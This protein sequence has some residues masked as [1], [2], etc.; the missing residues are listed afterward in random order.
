MDN[1]HEVVN[2]DTSFASRKFIM[3]IIGLVTIFAGAILAAKMLGF[4]PSYETMVGGVI[5]LVALYVS[6]N[7]GEKF[8]GGKINS[9]VK[10]AALNVV[11]AKNVLDTQ[12]DVTK[13]VLDQKTEQAII[14]KNA[15]KETE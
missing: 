9:A 5:G 13:D 2:T 4:A 10:I 11:N 14:E 3:V 15:E 6:G 12:K 1:E 8:F 7:V